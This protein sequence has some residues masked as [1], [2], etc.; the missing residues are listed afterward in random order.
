MGP[1]RGGHFAGGQA[2]AMAA[3][4]SGPYVDRPWFGAP[5]RGPGEPMP[6]RMPF[7]PEGQFDRP[8]MGRHFDDPYRFDENV[9]GVKRPF[10]MTVRSLLN[11]LNLF[12]FLDF[13][14]ER[15]HIRLFEY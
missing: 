6:P 2:A 5:E 9:H 13:F 1:L 8:F 7:S 11:F 10:H 12:A 3:G 14:F 4:P 15:N